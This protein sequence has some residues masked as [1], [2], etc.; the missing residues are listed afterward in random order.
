MLLH[1]YPTLPH[2]L[3]AK[4]AL[5][6]DPIVTP[7]AVKV[8]HTIVRYRLHVTQ[9]E[10]RKK[11]TA[12]VSNY[13]RHKK[14]RRRVVL[15]AQLSAALVPEAD[16]TTGPRFLNRWMLLQGHQDGEFCRS[17]ASTQERLA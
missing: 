9:R 3:R 17:Y 13:T 12:L 8:T 4:I 15:R 10:I 7:A 6:N 1:S 5:S 2:G 16:R 14:S 11:L